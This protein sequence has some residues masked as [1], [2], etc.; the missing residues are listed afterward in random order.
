MVGSLHAVD[1]Y[2]Q[3]LTQINL[4]PLQT[5][6]Q[7]LNLCKDIAHRK[8]LSKI[9]HISCHKIDTHQ[10]QRSPTERQVLQQSQT[11]FMPRNRHSRPAEI[12]DRRAGPSAQSNG[13]RGTGSTL[14]FCR[15][16]TPKGRSLSKI[17]QISWHEID[18]HELQ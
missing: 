18:T 1:I 15:D 17:K 12:T 8:A 9:K 4:I 7:S 13:C 11:D 3:I 6:H 16:C 2:L 10:L 5:E 14:T